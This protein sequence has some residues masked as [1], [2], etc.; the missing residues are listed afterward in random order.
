MLLIGGNAY[1]LVNRDQDVNPRHIRGTL[2]KVY[3]KPY[4]RHPQ[5]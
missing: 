4:S 5:V 1:V 2:F 3:S